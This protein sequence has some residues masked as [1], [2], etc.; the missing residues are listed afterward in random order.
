MFLFLK[1]LLKNIRLGLLYKI[2]T[3]LPNP[4]KHNQKLT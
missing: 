3:K 2:F 4:S 1:K